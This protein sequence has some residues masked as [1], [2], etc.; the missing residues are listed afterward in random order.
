MNP[1]IRGHSGMRLVSITF[2]RKWNI[3]WDELLNEQE[4]LS[5]Q[6]T[7]VV[8]LRGSIPASEG[9]HISA[10]FSYTKPNLV[11][12]IRSSCL[13]CFKDAFRDNFVVQWYPES[14]ATM[15]IPITRPRV[16]LIDFEVAIQFPE[17]SPETERVSMGL[18]FGG[19]FSTE[20]EK[21]G[22]RHA[23]EF[24]SG[25][26]YKPFKLDV[27]HLARG[28]SFSDFKVRHSFYF[29]FSYLA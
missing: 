5:A 6:I 9:K 28:I 15:K 27:W 17:E 24:A 20:L 4:F 12:Y 25:I 2:T 10:K 29:Y 19:S 13:L 22:R 14:L 26:A 23:P 11:F 18:P 16:Y 21:Y 1:L 8:P 3:N 7:P